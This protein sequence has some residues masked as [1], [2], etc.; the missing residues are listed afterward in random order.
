MRQLKTRG[1]PQLDPLH[2]IGV[3][4]G[5]T[6]A[7]PR[8]F[9]DQRVELGWLGA[10]R[11]LLPLNTGGP[12]L[13][14]QF[15]PKRYAFSSAG[16]AALQRLLAAACARPT[17]FHTRQRLLQITPTSP[18][19]SPETHFALPNAAKMKLTTSG[20]FRTK[21]RPK[22]GPSPGCGSSKRACAHHLL[23]WRGGLS[24]QPRDTESMREEWIHW[25]PSV[26]HYH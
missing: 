7:Q 11:P 16:G 9:E 22:G 23:E 14:Q 15:S 19:S 10:V 21:S 3:G 1:F 5:G 25:E 2:F 8:P 17:T 13:L 24:A 18:Q 20:L 4:G 26:L 6:Q 12:P